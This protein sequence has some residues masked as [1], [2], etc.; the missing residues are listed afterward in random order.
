VRFFRLRSVTVQLIILFVAVIA[1]FEIVYL[2]YRYFDRTQGLTALETIRVADNIAVLISLFDQTPQSEREAVTKHYKGSTLYVSWSG[3]RRSQLKPAKSSETALLHDLL[4]KLLPDRTESDIIVSDANLDA[5][6]Q[7][8][9]FAAVWKRAAPFPE[10]V[11]DIVAEL[12]DGPGFRIA[13]R[14]SDGTWLNIAAAYVEKIDFWPLRSVVVLTILVTGIGALSIWAI[15]R[16]TAPF[17]VFASAAARLGTDVNAPPLPEHGPSEVRSAI[18]AFNDM[19]QRLQRFVEGRTQMLAAV[20]HD[21][22][23][24]IT[25]LR[26]RAECVNDTAQS[27]KFLHDLKEMEDMIEGVLTFAQDEAASEPTIAVDLRAMLQSLCDELMDRGFAVS[28]DVRG[29]CHYSCRRVSMRRCFANL[30]ENAVK[31]GQKAEVSLDVG[32]SEISVRIEDRGPGIPEEFREQ[33]FQPFFRL[34]P[35]RSRKCGGSGLGLTIARSVARAHGGDVRLSSR[36]GGGLTATVT[37]PLNESLSQS[38]PLPTA[39]E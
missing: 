37:L 10:P 2:G 13:V 21:L 24:P 23:T 26:L 35:S 5:D 9:E 39:A 33:V 16:L 15:Q 38:T 22:R 32:A 17:R 29:R 14:L 12:A 8:N 1:L 7:Q 3:D 18:R 30:I 11:S 36:P 20:S 19:Q 4:M 25:R 34:E 28:F 31:Y 27:A 6:L